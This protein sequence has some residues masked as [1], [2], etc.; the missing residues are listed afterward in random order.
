MQFRD[1]IREIESLV[2]PLDFNSDQI[3]SAT[4]SLTHHANETA[5][6][7]S[8]KVERANSRPIEERSRGLRDTAIS[9]RDDMLIVKLGTAVR[10]PSMLHRASFLSTTMTG[11]GFR[12]S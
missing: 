10:L 1:Y 11:L 6:R 12:P 5:S 9:Y 3:T 7:S 4:P 2:N 8:A